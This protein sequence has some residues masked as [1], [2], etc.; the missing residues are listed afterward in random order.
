MP[1]TLARVG[2]SLEVWGCIRPATYAFLDTGLPQV[3][4]IQFAPRG[5]LSFTTIQQVSV[6]STGNCYFDV[7]I[8]LPSSGS[9]RLTYT[10]P[11]SDPLLP[12]GYT[13]YSRHITITLH[14]H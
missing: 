1:L 13:I 10:Y 11:S 2:Q 8:E 14:S 4:D 5:S 3:A 12:A 9:I 7:P 6:D